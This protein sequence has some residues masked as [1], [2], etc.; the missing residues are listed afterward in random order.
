MISFRKNIYQGMFVLSFVIL[1]FLF[2]NCG[3]SSTSPNEEQPTER[4]STGNATA[5]NPLPSSPIDSLEL[6][7]PDGPRIVKIYTTS[8]FLKQ[9]N[10]EPNKDFHLMN[11]IDFEGKFF[12]PVCL[13]N[14]NFYGHNHVIK[15]IK[16]T[17]QIKPDEYN[18]IFGVFK[19]VYRSL[20][21]GVGIENF[22]FRILSSSSNPSVKIYFGGSLVGSAIE[23]LIVGVFAKRG[24][25]HVGLPVFYVGGLIGQFHDSQMHQ[26]WT[27]TEI[28][29]IPEAN[30]LSIPREDQIAGLLGGSG[31]GGNNISI[32]NSFSL[33]KFYVPDAPEKS[34]K[35]S[36]GGMIFLPSKYY[37]STQS[38]QGQAIAKAD[39]NLDTIWTR[40]IPPKLHPVG[41]FY[42]A[43]RI[44]ISP[45][46]FTV[47]DLTQC[48]QI[49]VNYMDL[50]NT[51]QSMPS[52]LKLLVQK[53]DLEIYAT[54]ENCQAAKRPLSEIV[55]KSSVSKNEFFIRTTLTTLPF[56]R[57]LTFLNLSF[58]GLVIGTTKLLLD[59]IQ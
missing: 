9:K 43:R 10:C 45:E 27:D 49:K 59:K 37:D 16:Y 4:L 46:I 25:L 18:Y 58:D 8:D 53:K 52:D 57:Y 35:L 29:F 15:N 33:S 11:D 6:I 36:G 31:G 14:S 30:S 17:Y 23:S 56:R 34:L 51:V 41:Y 55:L 3:K 13:Q 39:W 21:Y 22:E 2:Q 47:S 44:S 28:H 50:N 42:N 26:S 38:E 7:V 32:Y 12:E 24:K 5:D 48:A 54:I 1:A 19:A 40:D 20:L